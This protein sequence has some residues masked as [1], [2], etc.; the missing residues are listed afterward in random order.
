MAAVAPAAPATHAKSAKPEGFDG[1]RTKYQTFKR[2]LRLHVALSGRGETDETKVMMALSYMTTGFAAEWANAKYA[3]YDTT[4]YPSFEDFL[5]AMDESFIDTSDKEKARTELMKLHQTTKETASEWHTRFETVALRAGYDTIG[6][7]DY[8]IPIYKAGTNRSIIKRIYDTG[9]LPVTYA[10]WKRMVQLI[11]DA[12]HQFKEL[13]AG[14]A[15]PPVP[16]YRP[17]PRKAADPA[18]R[19]YGYTGEA[20]EPMQGVQEQK[21]RQR[22]QGLCFKCNQ[23][24][25][26]A[27]KCASVRATEAEV[28]EVHAQA[29]RVQ[30]ET[31]DDK[32]MDSLKELM[33]R[34]SQKGF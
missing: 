17:Q 4:A 23:K 30:R 1:S 34:G 11:D 29:A 31:S 32:I 6:H 12:Y 15:A 20:G 24:W 8:L 33:S 26:P 5:T 10:D 22:K 14:K 7:G 25:N 27:H 21:A 28:T 9:A 13:D 16:I 2:Q 18:A 19:P 3:E